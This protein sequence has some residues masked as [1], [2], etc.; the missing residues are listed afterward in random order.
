MHSLSP[1]TTTMTVGRLLAFK[2]VLFVVLVLV[3]PVALARM[4][5]LQAL[6]SMRCEPILVFPLLQPEGTLEAFS[7]C[8]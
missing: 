3:P 1:D 5:C 2:R 8:P 4:T 7:F 6:K